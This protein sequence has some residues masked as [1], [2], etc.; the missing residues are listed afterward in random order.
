M[1]LKKKDLVNSPDHYLIGG[2]ET[3]DIIKAKM[4]TEE[5]HGFLKGNVLKYM[6]RSGYKKDEGKQDLKKANYYLGVL[7]DES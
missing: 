2:I 7:I 3:L 4:T 5:Y 1:K 6:C